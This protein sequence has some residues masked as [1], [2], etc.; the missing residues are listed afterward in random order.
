MFAPQF[1]RAAQV[2]RGEGVVDH[3]RDVVLPGDGGHLFEGEDGDIRVAQRFA[4]EDL[5]I[6]ADGLFEILRVGRDRRR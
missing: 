4:V 6:G 2:G 5:G 3:Q 1:E